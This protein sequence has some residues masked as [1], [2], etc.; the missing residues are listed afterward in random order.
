M[1]SSEQVASRALELVDPVL[2]AESDDAAIELVRADLEVLDRELL[3][4]VAI[5]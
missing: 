5:A 2:A 1:E 3:V 4:R